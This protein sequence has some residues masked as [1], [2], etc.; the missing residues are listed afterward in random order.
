[1]RLEGLQVLKVPFCFR[2]AGPIQSITD[3]CFEREFDGIA[4]DVT[5]AVT[6]VVCKEDFLI[7][8]PGLGD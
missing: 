1:M 2:V 4:A 5:S 7:F 3:P 6:A 8:Q